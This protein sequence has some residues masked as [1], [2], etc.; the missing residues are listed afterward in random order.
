M[1]ETASVT[2]NSTDPPFSLVEY[3]QYTLREGVGGH[4]LAATIVPSGQDSRTQQA[5]CLGLL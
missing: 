5:S 3:S 1:T 4:I 2:R